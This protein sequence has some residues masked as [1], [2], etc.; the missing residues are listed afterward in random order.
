MSDRVGRRP[1]LLGGPSLAVLSRVARLCLATQGSW[2]AL[3]IADVGM[4]SR[5]SSVRPAHVAESFPFDV[6][7]TGIGLT[8]GLATALIGVRPPSEPPF[9]SS[10][11]VST[12]VP[13]Y[14]LIVAVAGVL[15]A[16][17]CQET[18]RRTS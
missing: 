12:A 8:Y 18:L 16:F 4:G 14:V 10:G 3:L 7:A 11:A 1:L 5:R 15:A 17:R 6:R 9:S 13:L 2:P